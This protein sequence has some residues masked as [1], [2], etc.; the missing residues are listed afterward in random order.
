MTMTATRK[1]RNVGAPAMPEAMAQ[2]LRL[3]SERREVAEA[4]LAA[5]QQELR[6]VVREA[7]GTYMQRQI[8]DALGVTRGRVSQLLAT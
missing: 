1:R 2:R 6:E 3:A 7:A 8:A 5:A 4:E